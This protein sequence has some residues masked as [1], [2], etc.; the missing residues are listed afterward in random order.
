[1][2]LYETLMNRNQSLLVTCLILLTALGCNSQLEPNSDTSLQPATSDSLMNLTTGSWSDGPDYHRIQALLEKS[3]ANM[4]LDA[5]QGIEWYDADEQS[6]Q[7]VESIA[8]IR[9]RLKGVTEKSL[10][11]V[12]T[13]KA[14]WDKEAEYIE[15][16]SEFAKQLGFDT[17]V[18]TNDNSSALVISQIVQLK[19]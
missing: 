10:V 19:Q 11:C 18:V 5:H 2:L 15:S 8:S 17:I 1:M 16:I 3:K 9:D 14:M 13:G 12:G 7:T 4:R 6:W